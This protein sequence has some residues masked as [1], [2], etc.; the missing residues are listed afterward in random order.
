MRSAHVSEAPVGIFVKSFA[1]TG[2][3]IVR[4]WQ[5]PQI[6][7]RYQLQLFQRILL[8]LQS[9]R[10]WAGSR[11]HDRQRLIVYP[12]RGTKTSILLKFLHEAGLSRLYAARAVLRCGTISTSDVL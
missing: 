11:N 1:M 8:P 10:A 5:I 4:G 3:R 12:S 9:G 2:Y 6:H 7:L